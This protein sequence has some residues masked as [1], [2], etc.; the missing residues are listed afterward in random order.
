MSL[1]SLPVTSA[2]IVALQQ[3]ILFTTTNAA[4]INN[5]VSS[6]NAPGTTETVASY[7]NQLLASVQATSQMAMGVSALET[8][9]NQ[10]VAVLTNLVTNPGVIP[11]YVNFA[12]SKGLDAGQVVGESL[13]LAFS[14]APGFAALAGLSTGA[15][16]AA[17]SGTFGINQS[18]LVS[19]VQ[20]F[21]NLYSSAGG[22]PFPGNPNP[23]AAQ[24]QSAA[25]GAVFGLAVALNIEGVSTPTSIAATTQTQVKN[26]LFDIAQSGQ[27]PPGQKYVP[28]LTLPSHPVPTPFQ[29]GPNVTGVFLTQGNDT[30]TTGFATDANGTPKVPPGFTATV[31]NTV[32]NA[33][34]FV[35][36]IG[37][38]QQHPQYR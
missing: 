9:A 14:G 1:F 7:A 13:G 16:A 8:G 22:S 29:G 15:F 24:I 4:D 3:G 2:D 26:A 17:V 25:N 36:A 19:Q 27:S 35:T 20:F 32:F 5:Q 30:P 11:A 6:I 12:A 33:L 23:T 28:G 37:A 38:R 21:V 10:T 34:P 18:F 31:A